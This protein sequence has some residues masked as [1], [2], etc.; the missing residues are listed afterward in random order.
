MRYSRNKHLLHHPQQLCARVQRDEWLASEIARVYKENNGVYGAHK[1][2]KQLK[3]ESIRGAR[4][5]VE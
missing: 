4:C 2:W 1:V 3:R 5:T